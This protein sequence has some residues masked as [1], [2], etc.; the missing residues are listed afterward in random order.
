MIKKANFLLVDDEALIRDGIKSL[1]EKEVFVNFIYEASGKK[2]F[3]EEIK[4]R[5]DIILLDFRLADCNGLE[6]LEIVRKKDKS[7]R[8]IALTGFDGVELIL[9]L[10]KAGINGI[11]HKLDGYQEIRKTVERVMENESYFPEKVTAIIQKNAHRWDQV[12]PIS[13]TFMEKELLTKIA[14]GL[15]TKEIAVSLKM[16][17][18][19]TE[20]YRQRLMKKV[21]VSN[22]AALLAFAYRNGLLQ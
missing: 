9:N 16:P 20:T 18:A 15:T 12:A 2:Q 8:V 11:V 5:I 17:E 21:N 7:I 19:T 6:L 3:I 13:L 14:S 4:N 10:L 22:T 1:L